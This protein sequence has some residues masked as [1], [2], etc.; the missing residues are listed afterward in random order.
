[1][2]GTDVQQVERPFERTPVREVRCGAEGRVLIV[3]VV[4]ERRAGLDHQPIKV[5]RRQRSFGGALTGGDV[6]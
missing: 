2:P 1:M 3:R 4:R 5:R 6:L